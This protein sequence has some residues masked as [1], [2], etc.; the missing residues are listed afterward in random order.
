MLVDG[1]KCVNRLDA[2]TEPGANAHPADP[3]VFN[4][5]KGAAA[6]DL[7][8]AR[9]RREPKS[10]DRTAGSSSNTSGLTIASQI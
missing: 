2:V 6:T 8:A 10:V 7:A 3:E 5:G 1:S 9:Y 4:W